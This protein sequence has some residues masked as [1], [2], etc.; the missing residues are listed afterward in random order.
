[1]ELESLLDTCSSNS[2]QRQ[3]KENC[4][5]VGV[6]G[7][8]GAVEKCYFAMHALQHRGQ[9]SAGIAISDGQQLYGHTGMG[10]VNEVFAQPKQRQLSKLGNT[11]IGHVRYSTAGSSCLDNAQPLLVEYSLGQMAV[12]HNGNLI[13]AMLLR[14]E[15]EAHGHIFKG[16]SD[17]EIITHLMAKPTHIS[18]PDTLAHVLG[19]LQGAFCLLFLFPEKIEAA[20]DPYGIRPL[21]IGRLEDDAYAVTSETCALDIIDA[22]FIREVEPGEIVTL[23]KDGLHSRFFDGPKAVTPAHC[24]FE[25]VYFADPSSTIFGENVHLVRHQMGRQLAIESP[26]EADIVMPVPNC[27]RCAASGYADESKIPYARGFTVSHYAGRS[28]IEPEQP[29]RNLAVKM[30]LNVIK[31]VVRGKRLVVIEDSVVRGTTT[32]G[33]M[34]ALRRAGAKEIHLRVASPPI[35]FPCFYGIDFPSRE[36]LIANE[37]TIEEIRQYLEIDSL[38]YLSLDGMLSCVKNPPDHYCN[39]CWSGNYR[40]PVDKAVSKYV[41]ER[42]QKRL[43]E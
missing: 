22:E 20:R 8:P 4:G 26:A 17:S 19:H 29:M 7:H 24:I 3:A 30:K 38:A 36:E 34:G 40:I 33:K 5:L 27:A 14:D 9:E 12:A 31:E 37:R 23:D 32:R 18:K 11:A 35:R 15:Y 21:C 42:Y 16:T 39:A 6:F 13:N 28:F 10:L 25:Q 43:F 41:F 2:S 1:M